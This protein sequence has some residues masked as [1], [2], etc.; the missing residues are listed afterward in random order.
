M[1]CLNKMDALI[2]HNARPLQAFTF[3]RAFHLLALAPHP[4]DFDAIGA[5]MRFF[6]ENGNPI[7]VA[8]ATSGASGVEDTFCTPPT[9]ETKK[10]VRE[11]EQ[12]ASCRQ[13]NINHRG[14]GLDERILMVDRNSAESFPADTPYTEV[15]ELELFGTGRFEDILKERR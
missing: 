10:A 2:S 4:D 14:Y 15:F 13:R 8:V 1:S 3:S 6:K 11:K 9:P 12:R 7:H 5:T